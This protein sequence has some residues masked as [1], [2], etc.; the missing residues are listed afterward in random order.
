M[1]HFVVY[2]FSNADRPTEVHTKSIDDARSVALN[3][4]AKGLLARIYERQDR[5]DGDY[6]E[7]LVE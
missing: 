7:S 3:F 4:E 1:T 6:D 5:S 2:G